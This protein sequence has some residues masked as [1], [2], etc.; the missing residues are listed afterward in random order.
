MD[1][2]FRS[3][4][5]SDANGE[6]PLICIL[7]SGHQGATPVVGKQKPLDGVEVYGKLSF[8]TLRSH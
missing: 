7:S 4:L 6:V 1:A 3:R 5:K 2:T 8:P